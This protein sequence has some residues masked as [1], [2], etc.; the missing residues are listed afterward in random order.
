MKRLNEGSS[1]MEIKRLT[2]V[3]YNYGIIDTT[4]AIELYDDDIRAL[5]QDGIRVVS[6]D[7]VK[8]W[9]EYNYLITADLD[10]WPVHFLAT[11]EKA[12]ARG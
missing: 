6:V 5:G 1:L 10:G 9:G 2:E 12:K 11:L 8:G 4:Q 7:P 3:T